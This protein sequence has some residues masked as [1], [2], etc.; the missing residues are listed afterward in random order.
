MLFVV[1][2][3]TLEI[4]IM[5]FVRTSFKFSFYIWSKHNQVIARYIERV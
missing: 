5:E 2:L 1:I 3:M 4:F